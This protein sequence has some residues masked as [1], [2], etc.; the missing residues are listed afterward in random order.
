MSLSKKLFCF[1]LI[2][3][4]L[5]LPSYASDLDD[6]CKTF[7][8]NNGFEDGKYLPPEPGAKCDDGYEQSK[9]NQICCCK[10]KIET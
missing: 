5:N 3:L 8:T 9:E 7:C 2:G 1:L 4:F 6:E 10:P